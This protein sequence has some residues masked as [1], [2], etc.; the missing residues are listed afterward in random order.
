MELRVQ[1][2]GQPEPK[3][4]WYHD[5]EEVVTSYSTDM[6]LDGSLTIPCSEHSHSGVYQLVAL[7]NSGRAAKQCKVFVRRKE[8]PDS[9]QNDSSIPFSPVSVLDFEEYVAKGHANDETIF[10]EQF[11]VSLFF[12]IDSPTS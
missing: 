12:L 2:V 4:T 7:N 10:Q 9:Q 6:G 8:R 1:V 11:K 3:L 5:G